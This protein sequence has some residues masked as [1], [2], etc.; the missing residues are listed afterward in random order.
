M[1]RTAAPR[2]LGVLALSAALLGLAREAAAAPAELEIVEDWKIQGIYDTSSGLGL[3]YGVF[4]D[5]YT[6][7]EYMYIVHNT[8]VSD[9]APPCRPRAQEGTELRARAR[10]DS[11]IFCRRANARNPCTCTT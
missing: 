9:A 4:F 8:T 11:R 1:A 6:H 10:G 7:D 3:S 5:P 2:L